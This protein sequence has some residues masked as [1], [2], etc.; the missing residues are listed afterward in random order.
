MD[1]PEIFLSEVCH[2]AKDRAFVL[3]KTRFYSLDCV[4]FLKSHPDR[5]DAVRPC[6][7]RFLARR[8]EVKGLFNTR[9]RD[10]FPGFPQIVAHTVSRYFNRIV[11]KNL[12]KIPVQVPIQSIVGEMHV[13]KSSYL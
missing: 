2:S 5:R 13:L 3:K 6:V 10:M 1:G 7:N 9:F 8:A 11:Q 4:H 12:I